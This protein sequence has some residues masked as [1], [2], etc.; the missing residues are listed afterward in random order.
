MDEF[1]K[2]ISDGNLSLVRVL[3]EGTD[4][5]PSG[6]VYCT[7]VSFHSQKLF[8]RRWSHRTKHELPL[9]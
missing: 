8:F 5:S 7:Q 3:R 6:G 4:P 9:R 1:W 2:K